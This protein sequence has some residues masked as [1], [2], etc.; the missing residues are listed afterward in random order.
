MLVLFANEMKCCLFSYMNRIGRV[1]VSVLGSS[2]I[3][4]GFEPRS[5]QTKHYKIGMCCLSAKH[6]ALKRKKES[7]WLY[8]NWIYSYLY[9]Q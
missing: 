6:A 5:G 3:D 2:V 4:L 8:G 9:Y 1:M 7:S